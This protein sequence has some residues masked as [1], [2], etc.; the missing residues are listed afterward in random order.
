MNY[1]VKCAMMLGNWI[2][3]NSMTEVWEMLYV[4]VRRYELFIRS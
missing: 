3:W 1:T 4:N 2:K